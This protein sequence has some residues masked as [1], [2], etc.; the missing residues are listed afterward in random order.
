MR[1]VVLSILWLIVLTSSAQPAASRPLA[2]V[3]LVNKCASQNEV[4]V[5]KGGEQAIRLPCSGDWSGELDIPPNDSAGRATFSISYYGT[6]SS[7]GGG[8]CPTGGSYSITCGPELVSYGFLLRAPNNVTYKAPIRL[9][10][11]SATLSPALS[12]AI[13]T[14]TYGLGNAIPPGL[15]TQQEHPTPSEPH[16]LAL[17]PPL[18]LQ[19]N[20]SSDVVVYERVLAETPGLIEQFRGPYRA[21]DAEMTG[22][23]DIVPGPDGAFWFTDSQYCTIGRITTRGQAQLYGLPFAFPSA[24]VIGITAGPDH[25]LWFTEYDG[26]VGNSATNNIN[27]MTT[28]GA[29]H[30]YRLPA[31]SA[32]PEWITTGPDGAMWFTTIDFGTGAGGIGRITTRGEISEFPVPSVS[33]GLGRIIAGPDGAL[34]FAEG[35]GRRIGRITTRGSVHEFIVPKGD[36]SGI[37][38]GPD[39]AL[40]FTAGAY[41]G[42][43]TVGGAMREFALPTGV[44]TDSRSSLGDIAAGPDGALWFTATDTY[45]NPAIGRISTSG[46]ISTYIIPAFEGPAVSVIAGPD[47]GMWFTGGGTGIGRINVLARQPGYILMPTLQ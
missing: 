4:V 24:E 30:Q 6:A 3:Q 23:W 45:G 19:P 14:L 42:R 7:E 37:T 38:V 9:T 33:P 28:S 47:G 20:F 40:W 12:Y 36:P 22:P 26:L 1:F 39:H 41:V 32:G 18:T 11:K 46:A 15:S 31:G 21:S 16:D 5:L 35:T 29:L 8:A 17:A 25:A 43:L 27:R 44:S 10:L 34:W 2:Q 13:Q